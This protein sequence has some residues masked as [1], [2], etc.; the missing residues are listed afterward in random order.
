[1]KGAILAI[2]VVS[3]GGSNALTVEN[4]EAIKTDL[5]TMYNSDGRF[6][7][8]ALRLSMNPKKNKHQLTHSNN[9]N[10]ILTSFP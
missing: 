2:L 10:F 4:V 7:A 1:M 3:F 8:R 5:W 9:P 6:M